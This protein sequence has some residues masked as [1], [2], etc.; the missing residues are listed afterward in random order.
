MILFLYIVLMIGVITNVLFLIGEFLV[1][2]F[3]TSKFSKIWRS[4]ISDI[5][6]DDR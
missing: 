4:Y 1:G 5:D 6:P 2:K 3:P